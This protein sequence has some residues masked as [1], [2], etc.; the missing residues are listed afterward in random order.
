MTD[1]AEQAFDTALLQDLATMCVTYMKT[2]STTPQSAGAL[3]VAVTAMIKERDG[4]EAVYVF[5]DLMT[6]TVGAAMLGMIEVP[7]VE[8]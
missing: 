2:P 6:S 8:E 1:Q 5:M 7:E 4:Q 3:G